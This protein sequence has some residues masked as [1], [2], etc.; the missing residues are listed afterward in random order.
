MHIRA[1]EQAL[2]SGSA[3]K[4]VKFWEIE[5]KPANKTNEQGPRPLTLTHVRTLKMTDD[6][7]SVRYSPNS[8]LLAVALLDSTVKVF[9]Q[10]TLKFFLS[11]YGH[12]LPVLSM[13]ISSD[14]KLIVTCSADKNVKI[15]GLDFGD[16]H[17]SIFAHDDSVMQVAFEKTDSRD[18]NAKSSH[19]F[20]TVGKDKMLKY[21]DGDKFE[22]IQKLDGHHGEIWALAVS[23]HGKFVVTGSHDKSIRIWEKLDE[24]LFIEEER[25]RELERLYETGIADT[26]NREDA[27]IGSGV[28]GVSADTGRAEATSVSKQTTETLVAGERII[29]AIDLA[30]SELNALREYEEAKAAGGLSAQIAPPPRNPVLAAYE[31]EPEEYVLMVIERVSSTALYDALLVLPF[32]KVVSLMMFLSYWAERSWNLILTSRVIF[33]LLKTHHHQIVANRV[34]RTALIPLRKHLRESLRAQKDTLSY[35][36]AALR[37]IKRQSDAQRTAEFHEEELDEDAVKARIAEGKKRKRVSIR[38]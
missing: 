12:K 5:Q 8:K 19:Y 38:V 29:E 31:K 9:Y 3:D 20:W 1:D 14:S 23:H 25:E 33:F 11:L 7:L 18:F 4:D 2:V 22:N 37:Y 21:W 17:R 30:E 10:D 28:E 6:V 15:W 36:L 35:N 34:M 27:P 32:G 24:P 16:C 13:D 26:L